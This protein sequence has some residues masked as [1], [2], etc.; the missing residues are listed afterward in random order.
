LQNQSGAAFVLNRPDLGFDKSAAFVYARKEGF[1]FPL[2]GKSF[3]DAGF[4]Y[5]ANAKF[6]STVDNCK[7]NFFG[8]RIEPHLTLNNF[9]LPI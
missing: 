3:I 1:L 4:R 8:L 2:R 9:L 6:N 5:E 7:V